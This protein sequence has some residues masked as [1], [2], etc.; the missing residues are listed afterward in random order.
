MYSGRL[1]RRMWLLT[2]H[3]LRYT[4]TRFHGDRLL[5]EACTRQ[6]WNRIIEP[7]GPLGETMPPCLP[8]ARSTSW[9]ISA[10]STVHSG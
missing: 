4:L 1:K 2:A 10:L 3:R 7:A 9:R 8:P 5:P 6:L